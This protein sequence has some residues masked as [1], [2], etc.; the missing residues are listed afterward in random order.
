MREAPFPILALGAAI[1]ALIIAAFTGPLALG[2]A[3]ATLAVA[4]AVVYQY[5]ST[6]R[7][8]EEEIPLEDFSWWAD[9][10]EPA[11][12]LRNLK[13]GDIS[14]AVQI[15]SSDLKNLSRNSDLLG[16]RL[17]LLIGRR[18]FE[19]LS[20]E[21]FSGEAL[22]ISN[23]IS[24]LARGMVKR[25]EL[26]RG[27]YKSLEQYAARFDRM[28]NRLYEFE[29]GKSEIIQ[30]YIDPLRRAAESLSRD[31]RKAASNTFKFEKRTQA[32]G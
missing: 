25:G 17:A 26:Q 10:G 22:K 20:E 8:Q 11:A 1:V 9:V 32:T 16:R 5:S 27:F 28:G 4:I 13:S 7:P 14:L 23:S 18:D 30:I 6:L 2:V 12:A 19:G 29:R 21:D 31:L 3:L 15:I 24:E